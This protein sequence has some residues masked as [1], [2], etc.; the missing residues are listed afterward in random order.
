MAHGNSPIVIVWNFPCAICISSMLVMSIKQASFDLLVD[1]G[2]DEKL[3]IHYKVV[4]I[5]LTEPIGSRC[6]PDGQFPFLPRQYY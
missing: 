1:R 4:T 5:V 6:I 3:T 2:K